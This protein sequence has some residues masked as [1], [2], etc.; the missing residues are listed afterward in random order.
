MT[1]IRVKRTAKDSVF[2]DLFSEKKNV[3]KLY[4]V[5]H[6]EDKDVTEDDIKYLT[7]ENVLVNDIYNDLGFMIAD[8]LIIL[9]EAQS[10]WT[11][12]ILVRSFLY[13]ATTYKRYFEENESDYYDSKKVFLPEPELYV[14]YTGDRKRI[15]AEI[16]LSNE[17][18]GGRNTSL[19][20]KIKVIHGEDDGIIGEYVTFCKVLNDQIRKHGYTETAIKETIRICK[21]KDVLRDYLEGRELEV[22][23]MLK[24]LYDEEQL[25]EIHL[26]RLIR[27]NTEEVTSEVTDKHIRSVI[28]MLGSMGMGK[29]EMISRL[30]NTFD[31]DEKKAIEYIEEC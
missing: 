15:P 10:T 25:R 20:V 30:M 23:T 9:V 16:S 14:L 19:D 8:R 11:V 12:N 18:F 22:T 6:A 7:L 27:E 31:I 3:L 17:F 2:T 1:E 26:K 5:L 24:A 13:L 21:D 4:R 28:D 29:E